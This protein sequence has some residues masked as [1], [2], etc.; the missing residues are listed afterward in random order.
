M[1]E[2]GSTFSVQRSTRRAGGASGTGLAA[3]ALCLLLAATAGGQ[4]LQVEAAVDRTTAAVNEQVTLTV[5]VSGASASVPQPAWPQHP[6]G[7]DVYAGG[8][9]QNVSIINGQVSSS[10]SFRYT[11]I[12]RTTGTLTVPA[13][14]LNH[15][16]KTYTTSPIAITVTPASAAPDAA[17]PGGQAAESQAPQLFITGETDRPEVYVGQQVTYVFRMFRRVQLLSRPHFTPPPFSGFVV[18]DLAPKEF[19]M[20]H[21]G[22]GY[23]VSELKYA[24]FPAA[25][26]RMTIGPAALQVSVANVANPDPFMAFFQSGRT[27]TL[28]TQPVELTVLPLPPA[29]RPPDFSGAVGTYELAASLDRDSVEAGNPVTLT[30]EISG[31]G[32]VKSLKEPAWPEMPSVRRYEPVSSLNVTNSGN[33]ISGARTFK[34]VMIPQTSGKL[35]VPPIVYPVFDPE[36]RRYVTHRTRPLALTVKPGRAAAG[37][38]S[39]RKDGPAGVESLHRDIRFLK[40]ACAP[41]PAPAGF[42]ASRVYWGLQAIPVAFFLSGALAAWLRRRRLADP[43]GRRAR[44]ALRAA[45]RRLRRAERTGGSEID[46]HA[47]VQEAIAGYFADKWGVSASGLT[48]VEIQRR[49]ESR[50]LPAET[51]RRIRALWEEAD[52][53][54]YAPAGTTGTDSR[55]RLAEARVL[56]ARLEE[57]L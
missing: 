32:L 56:L 46:F 44:G 54:R 13:L 35:T 49:L 39:A 26:G 16:G 27:Q 2:P 9:S 7:F 25:P 53:I 55:S 45:Q 5:Q 57:V 19:Q 33:V 51:V 30:V 8:R 40:T 42:P 24:L 48:Q 31:R 1:I 11:L 47:A 6:A 28:Q 10:V 41:A 36:K 22:L 43:A 50:G 3:L 17:E 29:G 14:S 21:N 15:E 52:L 38:G 37:T 4:E 18:E 23:R 20:P 34:V 12:P